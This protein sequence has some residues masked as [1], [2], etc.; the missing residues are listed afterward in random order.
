VKTAVHELVDLIGE[1]RVSVHP[2]DLH[3]HSL[4]RSADALIARRA[5]G[6][7]LPICVVRP[8]TSK[9][10]AEV[11][12]W[13]QETKTPVVP[14]GG[15]S[16]V[17]GS[18][19]ARDFVVIELR[20]LE[21]IL[22]FDEKS[23]LVTAQAGVTGPQLTKALR[24]WG[25]QL[26]HEPQSIEIST[27]GGWVATRAIGQLSAR[28]GG[29]EDMIAG[30]EAVL[31]G[32]EIVRT[33][34]A[35]RRAAGPDIGSLMIGSEGTLGVVTEVTLRVSPLVRHRVDCCIRFDHLSE[36]VEA[37][38]RIAQSY[39]EPTML[40]LYDQ[41][42]SEI[43]LRHHPDEERGPLMLLS[44]QGERAEERADAAVDTS[45]GRRGNPGLV[46]HWW[47]HRNDA[48]H[49]YEHIMSGRGILGAHAVVDTM[50]VAGTWSGLRGL[51]HSMKESLGEHADLVG[52]HLSHVYRDGSCLY[53]TL[54]AACENDEQALERLDTWWKVGME[55]CLRAGGT[56]SHH[57]GIGRRK[58]QWLEQEMGGWYSVLRSV[59]Q[60]IDPDR[61]MNPGALGL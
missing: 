29:I 35:P 28:Y 44:F 47:E 10:V 15:G 19:V 1:H 45:G 4:D 41:E 52:C 27:V 14:Y 37:A 12:R 5:G 51:Y 3:R 9:Q 46:H 43:F 2:A 60:A 53:F 8:H 55:Q 25:Y 56:I 57:H 11:L 36:G 18:I 40:R 22:D 33:K 7:G 48:V 49:D 17:C 42:D 20:A 21:E 58:A 24:S 34:T 59:K 31:P 54:A 26:G 61:I 30:V 39:L 32:G 16:G 13:A 6:Y 23:M 50:E 38:R